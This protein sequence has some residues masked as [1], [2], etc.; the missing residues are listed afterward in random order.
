MLA[1]LEDGIFE[2]LPDDLAMTWPQRFL[3]AIP[4]GADLSQVGDKFLHWLCRRSGSERM[5][6]IKV[7]KTDRAKKAIR[8]VADLY[9]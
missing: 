8:D 2:N 7:A 6:L 5:V 3:E 1:R 9:A 4:V